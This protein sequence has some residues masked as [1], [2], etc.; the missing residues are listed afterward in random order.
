MSIGGRHTN[1]GTA[2]MQCETP[3]GGGGGVLAKKRSSM[4]ENENLKKNPSCVDFHLGFTPHSTQCWVTPHNLSVSVNGITDN[5]PILCHFDFY[6]HITPTLTAI[7]ISPPFCVHTI[8]Y[9][10]L[11]EHATRPPPRCET[12]FHQWWKPARNVD[13]EIRIYKGH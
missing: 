7:Q 12:N 8:P 5:A 2:T 11:F 9:Q 4:L 1:Q 10:I 13:L 3:P 6:T